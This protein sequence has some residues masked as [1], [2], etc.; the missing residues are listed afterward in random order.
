M[1]HLVR[2]RDSRFATHP[3]FRFFALN[4]IFRHRAMGR[5]RYLFS[6]DIANRTMTVGELKNALKQNDGHFISSK[7]VRCLQT[8]RGTRPYWHMEGAKLRDMIEQIGTPT[9]FYTLSMADLS[10]P[11]LHRF[12]PENP[13]DPG[14]TIAE[15]Y[16]IRY[17]NLANNPHIVS[18]YLSIKHRHLRETVF[19]HLHASSQSRV[20][21]FWYRVEWQAWGSG[22]F[23]F[24]EISRE[25]GC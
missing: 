24:L 13:F 8:V 5:G 4:L 6:K 15:S 23:F 11:D 10:W 12:M 19:Q 25:N 16:R 18:A 2:Y 9:L 7:I 1:K 20:T 3:R 14:I 17:R 21:D 22:Q